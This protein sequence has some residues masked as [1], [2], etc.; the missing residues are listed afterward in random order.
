MD[1]DELIR[2]CRDKDPGAWDEFVKSYSRIVMKSVRY[3]LRKLGVRIPSDEFMDIVQEIFLMIWQRGK[4]AILSD[5]DCLESWLA[6]ISLN[7]TS[8]YCREHLF[9]REKNMVFFDN[10]NFQGKTILLERCMAGKTS[11][12]YDL[13]H[14]NDLMDMVKGAINTLSSKQKLAF[15]LYLYDNKKHK[16]ISEIMSLPM[17]T[18]STLIRRAKLEVRRRVEHRVKA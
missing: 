18:V 12:G 5:P 6:V 7:Y 16:D 10:D 1:A 9:K 14:N 4:L 13:M 2:K 11:A 15:K 3:K 17:N 8:N